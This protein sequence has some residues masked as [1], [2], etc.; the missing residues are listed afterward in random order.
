MKNNNKQR[1]PKR[2]GSRKQQKSV[3][4]YSEIL[5]TTFTTAV[6]PSTVAYRYTDLLADLGSVARQRAV[7]MKRIVVRFPPSFTNL[8]EVQLVYYDP[9][10]LITVPASKPAYLSTTRQTILSLTIPPNQRA[11]REAQT[12]TSVLGI[13]SISSTAGTI[14]VTIESFC[15]LARDELDV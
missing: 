4:S 3:R 15:D 6:T 7:L 8:T 9:A 12:T 2:R 11:Y 1:L 13:Q 5:R 10:T 14:G